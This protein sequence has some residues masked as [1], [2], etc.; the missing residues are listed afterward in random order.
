MTRPRPRPAS[1]RATSV[2]VAIAIAIGELPLRRCGFR[3]SC[4]HGNRRP[5]HGRAR[6][7]GTPATRES[8]Q[9]SSVAGRDREVWERSLSLTLTLARDCQRCH[10]QT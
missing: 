7:S 4:W 1:A 3:N 6:E 2:A 8:G 5:E 9:P 10:G